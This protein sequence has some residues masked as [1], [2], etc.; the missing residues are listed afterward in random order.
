MIADRE[1]Q[2]VDGETWDLIATADGIEDGFLDPITKTVML[3]PYPFTSEW[4]SP[5]TASHRIVK[6][7]TDKAG[8]LKWSNKSLMFDG[9][10]YLHGA[11]LT[12]DTDKTVYTVASWPKNRPFMVGFFVHNATD[13][14]LTHK[15]GWKAPGQSVE[16]HFYSDGTFEVLKNG[17]SVG[18]GNFL[19]R[20]FY[21]S[22][23]TADVAP[24]SQMQDNNF[25]RVALIPCR[26][27]ELLVLT[28]RG[29]GGNVYF[30]DID[31]FDD[32]PIIAEPGQF[33]VY[34]NSA[35]GDIQIV[36]LQFKTSSHFLGPA[37]RFRKPPA[38]GSTF[39]LEA[40]SDPP[41]Y[42]VPPTV[43]PRLVVNAAPYNAD[44]VADGILAEAR[45]RVDFSGT[46]LNTPFIYGATAVKGVSVANTANSPTVL[47]DWLLDC[48]LT[49]GEEPSSVAM[50][51]TLADPADIEAAGASKIRTVGNR[52]LEAKIGSIAILT[53]RTTT[54][55]WEDAT[56]A[57]AAR[58]SLEAR[59]RWKTFETFLISDPTPLDGLLLHDAIKTLAKMPG[60]LDADLDVDVI[61]ADLRGVVAPSKGEFSFMPKVGDTP[62]EWIQRL[63]KDLAPLH[64]YG[65]KPTATGP[66]FSVKD[67]DALSTTPAVVLYET[68]AQAV[69]VGGLA[70][71]R[72][73]RWYRA[74]DEEVFEP[75]CN[76]YYVTGINPR[77]RKAIRA[78]EVDLASQDPTTAVASRPDNWLGE[79]RVAGLVDTSITDINL[80]AFAARAAFNRASVVRRMVEWECEFLLKNDG[81]PVWRGEC[82]ALY[83][84][85]NYRVLSFSADFLLEAPSG[86]FTKRPARYVGER[87]GAYP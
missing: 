29:G 26:R 60:Y 80:A 28:D 83:N 2:A 49:V 67:P 24:G 71:G 30:E 75:E 37:W 56:I 40:Y 25:V 15:A 57:A 70:A 5:S 73:D 54:P 14:V 84:K 42:D 86:S 77:T 16:T 51:M 87:I 21:K 78:K 43:T 64:F 17:Q 8:S 9:D 46:G 62:A 53:G 6:A 58:L 52:P 41:F 19:Q 59:D 61:D 69:S 20:D 39:A 65:W 12:S 76:E 35:L 33:W 31:D 18:G 81:S 22:S 3:A 72:R 47:D 34:V 79:V 63:M 11:D 13:A 85:G 7:Q 44:F 74:F 68:D 10:V 55:R 66:K 32:S 4:R 1:A 45:I 23:E 48:S 36:P 38:T 82:V 50:A 27:K